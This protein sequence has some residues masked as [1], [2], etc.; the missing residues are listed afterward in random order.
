MFEIRYRHHGN[1][2]NLLIHSGSKSIFKMKNHFLAFL[3]SIHDR[4]LAEYRG[5][6]RRVH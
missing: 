2:L 3:S 4:F 6:Y 1:K 5:V